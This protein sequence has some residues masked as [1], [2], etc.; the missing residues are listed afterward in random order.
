MR[1]P[2]VPLLLL[3]L[4][5]CGSEEKEPVS[6]SWSWEAPKGTHATSVALL[7][8]GDVFVGLAG[9]DG[10]QVVF[11]AQS[12][13]ELATVDLGD[14]CDGCGEI[15]PTKPLV[16]GDYAM[17]GGETPGRGP[18]LRA[19]PARHRVRHMPIENPLGLDTGD[20]LFD[21]RASAPFGTNQLLVPGGALVQISVEGIASATHPTGAVRAV[22]HAGADLFAI[23]TADGGVATWRPSDNAIEP[24]NATAI[25]LAGAA[26]LTVAAVVEKDGAVR[27]R[28]F[29]EPLEPFGPTFAHAVEL[30][31]APGAG[32]VAVG[33]RDDALVATEAPG[34]APAPR[35]VLVLDRSGKAVGRAQAPAPIVGIDV[36]GDGELVLVAHEAGVTALLVE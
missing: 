36:S 32:R 20:M 12:G 1:W 26:P 18:L 7:Q 34:E 21:G 14:L 22:A 33:V 5:A 35:S 27:L 11:L 4:A 29:E 23:L 10:A 19:E 9:E 8:N 25:R 3:L 28:R 24:R 30:A 13:E 31:V 17:F 6:R 2:L 16:V 15:V